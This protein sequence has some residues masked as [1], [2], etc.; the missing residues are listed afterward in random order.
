M[1]VHRAM[2]KLSAGSDV[3]TAAAII[4]I[5]SLLWRRRGQADSTG[6]IAMAEDLMSELLTARGMEE[7][8]RLGREQTDRAVAAA[9]RQS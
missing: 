1:T 2:S 6:Y 5:A 4:A 3:K 9:E 8:R 7:R